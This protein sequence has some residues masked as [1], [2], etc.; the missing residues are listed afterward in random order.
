MQKNELLEKGLV[1]PIMEEFYSIQGE[2]YNTGKAAYFIRIGGCDVGCNWCDVKESW[3]AR[4]HPITTIEKIVENILA[5]PARAVVIT[6]GE[7]LTYNLGPLCLEL[8]NR[9][10]E[11]FLETSGA[12]PF[13][14]LF[15]WV[16]VSA[17][18]HSPPLKEMLAVA[19]ELKI[20]VYE[21]EDFRWAEENKVFVRKGCKLF[22]QPEWS[23]RNQMMPAIVEYVKNKPEW[24]LS[25]QT[26][27]YLNIP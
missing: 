2:G 7:P 27:K 10:V 23:R 17:K 24:M 4:F 11:I 21:D 9:G 3:N 6:G 16:C 26:H 25:L 20:I 5:S 22:L 8:K 18:R 19:D 13:S 14:G 12:Y 15:D 1:L